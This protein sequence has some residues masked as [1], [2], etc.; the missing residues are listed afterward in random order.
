[1]RISNSGNSL[2]VPQLSKTTIGLSG[3][4][5]ILPASVD[6]VRFSARSK[7]TQKPV[8]I[9]ATLGPASDDKIGDLIKA[10][11][12]IFRLNFSH[13][14]QDDHAERIEMIRATADRLG[15]KVSILADIQGPKFRVAKLPESGIQ[16]KKGHL[17]KFGPPDDGQ[18]SINGMPIIPTKNHKMLASLKV[19]EPVLMDDGKLAL[20]VMQLPKAGKRYITCKVIRGGTLTSSKGINLPGTQLNIPYLSEKDKSDMAFAL[21]HGVD[22]LALS[23][24]RNPDDVDTAIQYMKTLKHP[25]PKLIAK[26]EKPEAVRPENLKAI[27][28][29]VQGVMIARGDL[30]I[31]I[32]D[33]SELPNL[34]RRIIAEA[35]RQGGDK[36]VIVATQMLESMMDSTM[37]S[38]ADVSDIAN[39]V[40]DG[41]NATMLSG[42]TAVGQNPVKAVA[43]MRRIINKYN[44]EKPRG[45]A[46]FWGKIKSWIGGI[47][48]TVR[49][50]FAKLFKRGN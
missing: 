19:G 37:P 28:E 2:E 44:P 8:N 39:A 18:A 42:E 4:G 11:V 47:V 10:G 34:Q 14:T 3:T 17:V 48:S 29:Q 5:Y 6:S 32:P 27:V 41:A 1:M 30:G 33:I 22:Y 50:W 7:K 31:E 35:K 49:G 20:E 16:L 40:R 13:G 24:V 23:F 46:G 43:M 45:V 26:I 15:R 25:L 38:R 12:N 9:V 21:S 36:L